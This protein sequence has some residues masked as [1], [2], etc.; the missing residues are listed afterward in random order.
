MNGSNN[1]AIGFQAGYKNLTGS[2]NVYIANAGADGES[3][4]IRIGTEGVH[5]TTVLSGRVEGNIV[6]RL[7]V[8]PDRGRGRALYSSAATAARSSIRCVARIAV[9]PAVTTG[10]V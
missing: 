7:S 3:G 10:S 2:A 4:V 6:G 1:V 9:A 5:T 8:G